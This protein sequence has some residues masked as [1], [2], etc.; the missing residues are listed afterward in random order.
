MMAPFLNDDLLRAMVESLECGAELAPEAAAQRAELCQLIT[1][2]LDQL[3]ENYAV[4]LE[5]K[6]VHGA[7]SREIAEKLSISDSATQSLL[8]RARS[9]F[10]ELCGE[11]LQIATVGG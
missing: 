5:L 7:S 3:P 4:A 9:A 11:A 2:T 6:Y 8:A 1:F 10:R